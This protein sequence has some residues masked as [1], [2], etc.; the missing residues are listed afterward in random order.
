MPASFQEIL[1]SGVIKFVV[2]EGVDG[3]ATDFLVHKEAMAQLSEP[4]RDMLNGESTAESVT[5]RN[6]C[7]SSFERLAQFAYTGD[8]TVPKPLRRRGAVDRQEAVENEASPDILDRGLAVEED[9]APAP[10]DTPAEDEPPM[11]E[12]EYSEYVEH[13]GWW[14][15]AKPAPRVPSPDQYISKK[16]AK[17]MERFASRI[18]QEELQP[19][20]VPEPVPEPISRIPVLFELDDPRDKHK[21]DCEPSK[22]F[23]PK[24]NYSNVFRSHAGLWILANSYGIDSLMALSLYKLRQTLIAFRINDQTVS[25]LVDLVRY[26]YSP[27]L[28]LLGDERLRELVAQYMAWN[29]ATLSSDSNFMALLREGGS[30]VEDFLKIVMQRINNLAIG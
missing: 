12:V 25:D 16:K 28:E 29:S 8:Y 27:Q 3:E 13:P 15:A 20:P 21:D 4:F 1:N 24:G 30:F 23:D 5:W 19:E 14:P 26:V 10:G 17:R 11:P 7:K 22:Q 18:V 9:S 2:G 6:V